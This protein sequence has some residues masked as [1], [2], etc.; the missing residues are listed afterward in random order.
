MGDFEDEIDKIEKKMG[1]SS[2]KDKKKG[3]L[4]ATNPEKG[5]GFVNLGTKRIFCHIKDFI[6]K[7]DILVDGEIS[8]FLK[9]TDK[10]FKAVQVSYLKSIKKIKKESTEGEDNMIKK[11]SPY[12]TFTLSDKTTEI[13]KSIIDFN[14]IYKNNGKLKY[15]EFN[16]KNRNQSLS[17]YNF[18]ILFNKLNPTF[19]FNNCNPELKNEEHSAWLNFLSNYKFDSK[20]LSSLK[21]RI[22]TKNEEL[23]KTY[24]YS[25]TI[26]L[27]V[28]WRLISGLGNTNFYETGMTLHHTLG[29]PYLPGSSI[30]G[31]VRNFI[32]SEIFGEKDGKQDLKG[33]E[34]RAL[35]NEKFCKMFGS[36]KD[37]KLREHIGSI[38][39]LD[40][41]PTN[42]IKFKVDIMNPHYPEYYSDNENRIYPTDYQTPRPITFLTIDE[43]VEFEFPIFSKDENLLNSVEEHLKN[44]LQRLGIG[45]KTSVGYG[46][47]Q[48]N[49]TKGAKK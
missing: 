5:F 44:A 33:A 36:P 19:K 45:A 30:K 23:K 28:D 40:A 4:Q 31:I 6:D 16:K 46:Y 47:F 32:I 39:F 15:M 27:K 35:D 29:I 38:I 1:I 41:F 2:H 7:P 17:D 22:K 14:A 26:K 10:G 18:N 34:K 8:F 25:K 20:L 24:P 37:S 13:V 48:N 12:P 3:F 49:Q 11:A 42:P 43:G 21:K 9:K